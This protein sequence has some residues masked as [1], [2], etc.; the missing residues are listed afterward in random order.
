MGLW[1]PPF[2]SPAPRVARDLARS[3]R[4]RSPAP[5]IRWRRG[6]P[7]R[8]PVRSSGRRSAWAVEILWLE[9]ILITDL[10]EYIY[11]IYIYQTLY[12]VYK[13]ILES[14]YGCLY[15]RDWITVY[16]LWIFWYTLRNFQSNRVD[17]TGVKY[18]RSRNWVWKGNKVEL[19]VI[20]IV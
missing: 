5:P 6:C 1:N 11:I 3:T 15:L 20:V 18:Y 13:Y 16:W 8:G 9:S 2:L 7:G 10:L 14:I 4:S 19:Y 17:N 12:I